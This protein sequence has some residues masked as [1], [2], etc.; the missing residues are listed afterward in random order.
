MLVST[1]IQLLFLKGMCT[2]SKSTGIQRD[3]FNGIMDRLKSKNP[4]G[5]LEPL[6]YFWLISGEDAV[7]VAAFNSLNSSLLLTN[8]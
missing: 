6:N 3:V 5:C 8:L 1:V 4:W 7:N 2:K